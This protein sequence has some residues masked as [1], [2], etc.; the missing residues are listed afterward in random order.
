MAWASRRSFWVLLLVFACG[1]YAQA[2]SFGFISYDD[3]IYA[4]D[5]RM[6]MQG[7]SWSGVRWA[8]EGQHIGHYH[9][10]TWLS[11]QLDASLFGRDARGH[12]ATNLLLHTASTLL[13]FLFFQRATGRVGRSGVV[14]LLFALHP[15]HVEPV[16][17][18][19]SRKDVL[20]SLFW[21]SALVAYERYCR[22]AS[23]LRY[24]AVLLA[25][26]A[27]LLSKPMVVTLPVVLLV[28]DYWPLRR[29]SLPG[30][31]PASAADDVGASEA[32]PPRSW[33]FLVVEKLP[34][35]CLAVLSSWVT[36]H[37]ASSFGQLR[38]QSLPLWA[39]IQN[40][41]LSY[42]IYL[43]ELVLP[44]DLSIH[45]E[46]FEAA[47]SALDLSGTLAILG[48]IAALAWI[49]RRSQPYL[50]AGFLFYVISFLPVI[51]LLQLAAH[52]VADRYAYV[53]SIGAFVMV[54]WGLHALFA[55]LPNGG[56]LAPAITG[57]IALVFAL[58]SVLQVGYWRSG[59]ELYQHALDVYPDNPRLLNNLGGEL[60]RRGALDEA[61]RYYSR[62]LELNPDF[63]LPM[64]NL[65]V[66]LHRRNRVPEA[67]AVFRRLL[68]LEPN[69]E[70][71]HVN[72]ALALESQ[73]QVAEAEAHFR[74]AIE[75]T[76][77]HLFARLSLAKLLNSAGRAEAAR[78]EVEAARTLYPDRKEVHEALAELEKSGKKAA[79]E[80]ASAN[81]APR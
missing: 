56:L 7:L 36:F 55:R 32:R 72:L 11:H 35:F 40:S 80:A 30:S 49:C 76:P 2:L 62:A 66:V 12:H 8:F 5:N 3:D 67:I 78:A 79:K 39:R 42:V 16:V 70:K 28:L 41:L 65:G 43:R 21:M 45:H 23:L 46:R 77:D 22:G 71:A 37:A 48:G 34:L 63:T 38:G 19:S 44:V 33:V 61:A 25:Y 15:L 29:L 47:P 6:V 68:Q 17:W 51:G 73:G 81:P 64:N 54:V 13:V 58:L 53:P 75:L 50:F 52:S 74:R 10:L 26:A 20:S 14:A 59:E 9:P 57:A 18:I 27:G 60:Q 31:A 69:N 4:F 1:V 24:A